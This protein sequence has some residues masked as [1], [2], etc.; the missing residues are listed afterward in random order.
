M[1]VETINTNPE[2]SEALL[3]GLEP[4]FTMPKLPIHDVYIGGTNLTTT[5][6]NLNKYLIK[7]GVP[8]QTIMSVTCIS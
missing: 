2:D 5:E 7:I 6:D 1:A 3:T 4:A 8:A